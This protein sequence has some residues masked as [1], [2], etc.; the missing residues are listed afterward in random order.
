MYVYILDKNT[1]M[2]NQNQG[3]FNGWAKTPCIMLIV[4]PPIIQ[5]RK[6]GSERPAITFTLIH[7]AKEERNG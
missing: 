4:V 7:M 5:T 3:H 2:L 6:P 1:D